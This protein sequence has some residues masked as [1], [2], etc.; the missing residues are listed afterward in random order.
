MND[1][2]FYRKIPN[3]GFVIIRPSS[4]DVSKFAVYHNHTLVDE[5]FDCADDAA[6]GAS[7]G[8]FSTEGAIRYFKNNIPWVPRNLREWSVGLPDIIGESEESAPS[9]EK[10][11]P[12]PWRPSDSRC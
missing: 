10:C 12:R 3:K 9:L 5:S 7:T 2:C 8:N 11:P 6:D 4:R 1:G